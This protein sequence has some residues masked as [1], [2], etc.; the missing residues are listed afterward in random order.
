MSVPF[1]TSSVATSFAWIIHGVGQA[2]G[3]LYERD[4]ATVGWVSPIYTPAPD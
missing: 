2:L 3:K 4:C 1:R